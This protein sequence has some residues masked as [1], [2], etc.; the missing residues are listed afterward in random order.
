MVQFLT[1]QR[2]LSQPS[3]GTAYKLFADC[4]LEYTPRTEYYERTIFLLQSVLHKLRT[5]L[6]LQYDV[7]NT[8]IVP[9]QAYTIGPYPAVLQHD[10]FR[11]HALVIEVLPFAVEISK[12]IFED[13]SD[14]EAVP[15]GHMYLRMFQLI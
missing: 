10:I 3:F 9:I 8:W 13:G 7:G 5:I 2:S 11:N 4:H 1:A 6:S 15:I 14:L 12:L